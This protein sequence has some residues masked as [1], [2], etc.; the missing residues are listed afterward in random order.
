PHAVGKGRVIVEGPNTR[1]SEQEALALALA[2]NELMT[3]AIKYGALSNES[4]T[5]SIRWEGGDG[6]PFRLVWRERGGP[7][8][9][10]PHKAGFGSRL[11]QRHVA[12]TFGGTA[13]ISF[14]PRGVS[15]EIRQA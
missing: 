9:V 12:A 3:N 14:D 10:V 1:L 6:T 15:Y 5:V 7:T 11:I 4:G 2:L 13:H 8:V